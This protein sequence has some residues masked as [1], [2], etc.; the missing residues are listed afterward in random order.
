MKR[1]KYKR[2]KSKRTEELRIAT[3]LPKQRKRKDKKK[4]DKRGSRGSDG[5]FGTWQ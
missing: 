4:R 3:K 5:V 2:I 1:N